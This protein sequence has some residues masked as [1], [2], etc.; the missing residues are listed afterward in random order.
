[1]TPVESPEQHQALLR[2]AVP[3]A[4]EH[5]EQQIAPQQIDAAHHRVERWQQE[6][7]AWEADTAAVRGQSALLLASREAVEVEKKLI[8][9]M[10][11]ERTFVRPLLVV[12]PR[13][14]V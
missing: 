6:Q 8:R 5:M 12:V 14:E 13:P 1:G 9:E 7:L 11:P 10:L 3:V 4:R 2:A